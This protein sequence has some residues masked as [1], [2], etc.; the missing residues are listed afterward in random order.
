MKIRLAG[1]SLVGSKVYTPELDKG[2]RN[3]YTTGKEIGNPYLKEVEIQIEEEHYDD[4]LQL[5]KDKGYDT[6]NM[7]MQQD[8]E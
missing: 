7:L 4:V 3:P 8:K 2:E 5:L 1:L 6:S